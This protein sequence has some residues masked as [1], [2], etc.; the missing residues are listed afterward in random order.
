[1]GPRGAALTFIPL[2]ALQVV[3]VQHIEQPQHRGGEHHQVFDVRGCGGRDDTVRC[4]LPRQTDAHWAGEPG[5]RAGPDTHLTAWCPGN[6]ESR[7]RLTE[8]DA[9]ERAAERRLGGDSPARVVVEHAAAQTTDRGFAL[10]PGRFHR[11]RHRTQSKCSLGPRLRRHGPLHR[12]SVKH[13]D[14]L[15]RPV[16]HKPRT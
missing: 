15:Y 8:R 1:M 11:G 9:E 14:A 16:R 10:L 6:T 3:T 12:S 2:L 4:E 13:R 5:A 7:P